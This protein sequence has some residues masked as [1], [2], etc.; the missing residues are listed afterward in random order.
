LA[1]SSF[2]AVGGGVPFG[3]GVVANFAPVVPPGGGVVPGGGVDG[4]A[5]TCGADGT[6]GFGGTDGAA[7]VAGAAPPAGADCGNVGNF[8]VGAA[9][10]FG[11]NVIRTVSFFGC[12]PAP[13]GFG[14]TAPGGKFGMFSAITQ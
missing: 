4:G 8:I 12:A 9:V 5:E 10:G 1:G 6:A 2:A 13:S 3:P 7:G 14:G 11:G